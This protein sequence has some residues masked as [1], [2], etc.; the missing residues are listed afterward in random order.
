VKNRFKTRTTTK[1]WSTD[2]V[3]WLRALA[4]EGLTT[5]DIATRLRRTVSAIRNKA[6]MHGISLVSRS[7]SAVSFAGVGE[8]ESEIHACAAHQ[9]PRANALQLSGEPADE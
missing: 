9:P 5:E 8:S 7:H 3:R 2:D 4:H 6:G 1:A